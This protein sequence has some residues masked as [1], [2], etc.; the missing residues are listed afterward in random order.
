MPAAL[1]PALGQPA[2]TSAAAAAADD[3][4]NAVGDVGEIPLPSITD[5]GFIDSA[6]QRSAKDPHV[7]IVIMYRKRCGHCKP[8]IRRVFQYLLDN[9]GADVSAYVV[10]VDKDPNVDWLKS[11]LLDANEATPSTGYW[12]HGKL[13]LSSPSRKE[14]VGKWVQV[15]RAG[16]A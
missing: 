16:T 12:S 14:S 9:P 3:G 11:Q 4:A 7:D 5:L 2:P 13:Q 6:M 1:A 8:E 15:A 10:E